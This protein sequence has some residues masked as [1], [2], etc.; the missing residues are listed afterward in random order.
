MLLADEG[1]N[2]PYAYA[3]MNDAMAHTPLSSV[4][5]VGI[6]IDGLP[7]MNACIHLEQLQVWKLLQC[8]G[9]VVCPEGLNRGL[10]AL[11]FDFKELP[12]WNMAS[13]DEHT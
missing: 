6:M 3:Q 4:G 11:L 5:H 1:P 9:W 10:E 8:R 7:S 2:L 12:L 13:T